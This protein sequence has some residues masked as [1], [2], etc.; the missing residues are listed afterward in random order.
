MAMQTWTVID[1]LASEKEHGVKWPSVV[2]S[3]VYDQFDEVCGPVVHGAGCSFGTKS[4]CT[5]VDEQ[6]GINSVV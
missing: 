5:H 3:T 4:A 6:L 2:N 1:P